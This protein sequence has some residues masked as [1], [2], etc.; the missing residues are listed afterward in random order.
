MGAGYLGRPLSFYLRKKGHTVLAVNRTPPTRPIS[1]GVL[2]KQCDVKLS[3]YLE[4]LED[5]APDNIIICWAPG[6]DDTGNYQ[7]A[8]MDSMTTLCQAIEKHAPGHVI[9]TS[10]TGLYETN[11]GDP[12]REVDLGKPQAE[13][14]RI[15]LQ[16]EEQLLIYSKKVEF[17]STIL[18][19]SGL[20]GPERIPGL[21]RLRKHEPIPG[22][23]NIW[24]NLVHRDDAIDAI[25]I[26]LQKS[27]GGIFNITDDSNTTR[28]ELYET[29]SASTGL[30][31][32]A[33][34]EP[35]PRKT[36]GKKIL[37]EKAQQE[38]GWKPKH[39]NY[40]DWIKNYLESHSF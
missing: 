20:Y 10:S 33:W 34:Q 28:S 3:S 8:Y 24:T 19:L 30:E 18:R 21:R 35:Q 2:F 27:P 6:K 13:N 22:H 16:A 40:K 15:L 29:I 38:L 11:Q 17:K 23:G 12:V 4:L 39:E 9:Y 7:I 1:L 37:A 26:C 36:E 32:P 14:A 31:M 25:D 5:F